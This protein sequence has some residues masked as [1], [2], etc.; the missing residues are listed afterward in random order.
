M[1]VCG[2]GD[3]V[4]RSNEALQDSRKFPFAAAASRR[5]FSYKIKIRNNG[6]L[7]VCIVECITF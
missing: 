1:C 2:D 6:L 5:F 7:H 3:D 4:L